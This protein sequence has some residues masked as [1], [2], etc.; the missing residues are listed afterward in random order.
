MRPLSPRAPGGGPRP[1]SLSPQ[2]AHRPLE[3]RWREGPSSPRKADCASF[4]SADSVRQAETPPPPRAGL[5]IHPPLLCA[6]LY[7]SDYRL[8]YGAQTHVKPHETPLRILASFRGTESQAEPGRIAAA[9]A[10]REEPVGRTPGQV[11]AQGRGPSGELKQT[12]QAT[13]PS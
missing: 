11:C 9:P 5:K 10:A 12:P 3:R 4:E 8:L 6:E 13:V 7:P 1:R 2:D